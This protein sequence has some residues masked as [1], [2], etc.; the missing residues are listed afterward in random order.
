MIRASGSRKRPLLALLFVI[1]LFRLYQ[2]S[3]QAGRIYPAYASPAGEFFHR[4]PLEQQQESG[5]GVL[6]RST[7]ASTSAAAIAAFVAAIALRRAEY[8]DADHQQLQRQ[9]WQS[10]RRHLSNV[11]HVPMRCHGSSSSPSYFSWSSSSEDMD[12][13]E[14]LAPREA[15]G[16]EIDPRYG[17]EKRLVP[18]GPNPLHN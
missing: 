8:M 5:G 18:T 9:Y 2:L 17:V 7:R 16:S 12:C 10:V 11:G 4:E 1:E 3:A 14:S 15:E 13:S 6:H